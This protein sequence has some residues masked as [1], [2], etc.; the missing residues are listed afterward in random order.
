MFKINVTISLLLRIA[1]RLSPIIIVHRLD[2]HYDPSRFTD[3]D[4]WKDLSVFVTSDITNFLVLR[5]FLIFWISNPLQP[6][7][8]RGFWHDNFLSKFIVPSGQSHSILTVLLNCHIS[9]SGEHVI[10]NI[11]CEQVCTGSSKQSINLAPII[12]ENF[13]TSNWSK[14]NQEQSWYKKMEGLEFTTDHLFDE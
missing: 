3:N 10:H 11:P 14:N 9:I 13:Q 1:F 7:V 6:E 2:Y 8:T 4:L 5:N 12:S